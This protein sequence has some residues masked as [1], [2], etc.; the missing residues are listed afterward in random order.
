MARRFIAHIPGARPLLKELLVRFTIDGC[1]EGL[2][3]RMMV[4]RS[5]SGELR[6]TPSPPFT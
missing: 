1:I 6:V 3:F 5:S 2:S 4:G